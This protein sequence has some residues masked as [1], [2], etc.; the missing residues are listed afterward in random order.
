M[1]CADMLDA[2]LLE[3][4]AP[5]AE[6]NSCPPLRLRWPAAA[7]RWRRQWRP[8]PAD[9]GKSRLNRQ[10]STASLMEARAVNAIRQPSRYGG[11]RG[12]KIQEQRRFT[13]Q[14]TFTAIHS[15]YSSLTINMQASFTR[16]PAATVPASPLAGRRTFA[17][18]PRPSLRS[19]AAKVGRA[20]SLRASRMLI[21]GQ[22]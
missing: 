13:P 5:R 6:H 22:D 14:F 15:T 7:Q 2:A 16:A 19:N 12:G 1:P 8:L 18:A 3:V 20:L 9:F 21:E 17:T 10:S 4:L 11:T